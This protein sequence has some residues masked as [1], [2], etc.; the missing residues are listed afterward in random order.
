MQLDTIS[1]QL[2]ISA[3]ISWAEE[4]TS[5][6]DLQPMEKLMWAGWEGQNT[7]TVA[8]LCGFL[9]CIHNVW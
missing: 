8:I 4:T 6:P 1:W 3:H 7:H 9:S 2:P 5:T